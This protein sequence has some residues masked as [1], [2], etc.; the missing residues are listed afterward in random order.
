V[1]GRRSFCEGFK[2]NYFIPYTDRIITSYRIGDVTQT[3]SR[4]VSPHDPR[5]ASVALEPSSSQELP[6]SI[7]A[8]RSVDQ[9]AYVN[10]SPNRSHVPFEI[11]SLL[12]PKVAREVGGPLRKK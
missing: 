8:S 12:T 5:E 3:L 4:F 11:P 6:K 1:E 10:L 7:A 2:D 9:A